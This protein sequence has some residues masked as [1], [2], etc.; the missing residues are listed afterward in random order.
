MSATLSG[1]SGVLCLMD[2][3]LI[4]GKD[5]AEHDD[6]LNK[7]LKQIESAEVTLNLNKC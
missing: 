7:V 4:F 2:D 1:L 3:V 6:R 5:Q